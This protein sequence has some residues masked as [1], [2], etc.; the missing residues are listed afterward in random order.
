MRVS[1]A[2]RRAA[3]IACCWWGG[4]AA[5]G[6]GLALE[7]SA[8]V[9]ARLFARTPFYPEQSRHAVAVVLAPVW[10]SSFGA[11]RS[12][13]AVLAPYLRM[14]VSDAASRY[15]DL[16][17]ASAKVRHAD[18]LWR[19]GFDSVFWGVAE[20]NHLIDVVNQ[21]DPR[22]DADLEA[23]LGQP[24]LSYT[25]FLGSFGR[26]EALWL[27]WHR[28]RPRVS[29]RSRQRTDSGVAADAVHGLGRFRR[30]DDWALRWSGSLADADLGFYVFRG[31]SRE[32]DVGDGGVETYRLIRQFGLSAQL[33][34]GNMLW[35]LEALH[36]R[37]HGRPF[38]A[39]VAGGEYTIA[40]AAGDLGL[41]FEWS[42]DHRDASAPPTRFSRS[43]F[44]G[45]RYR[46]NES[47]D[48]EL[49]MGVVRDLTH[50]A[51]LH[52]LEYSRRVADTMRLALVARAI[53]APAAS[54]YAALRRD[55]NLQVSLSH[56]F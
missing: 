29:A 24:M 32:P 56:N 55:A 36:R 39:H 10:K 35:K 23:K 8:G 47:A 16:R 27:P 49:L 28:E 31:L 12:W 26:L 18:N 41:L 3:C 13:E 6:D 43:A 38:W 17:E 5:A 2:V 33:P 40:G 44:G 52:K 21:V 48:S 14:D 19:A 22:A 1:A 50:H 7:G 20:S 15:L 34:Q 54:P 4:A 30:H 25:R 45:L 53:D 46:F 51:W 9:E 42:R 11:A 37:G